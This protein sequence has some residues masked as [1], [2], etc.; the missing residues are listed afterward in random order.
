MR[1]AD[2]KAGQGC[3]GLQGPP[4]VSR[5]SRGLQGP[6]E[7][8]AEDALETGITWASGQASR[9]SIW[10]LPKPGA[11]PP[12]GTT[13]LLRGTFPESAGEGY[14]H[15]SCCVLQQLHEMPVAGTRRGAQNRIYS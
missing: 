1:E 13:I 12:S 11:G 3:Q 15:L 7:P 6:P 4:G 2:G 14:K 8:P 9:T 5:A 10:G